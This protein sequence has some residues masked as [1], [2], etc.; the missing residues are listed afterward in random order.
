MSKPGLYANIHAKRA[1][2]EKMRDKGDKGA[3]SEQDFIDSAKTA[4]KNMKKGGF[5]DLTGDGKVTR[6]DILK[7][8]GVDLGHGGNVCSNRKKMMYGGG[9]KLYTT[10][11]KRYGGGVP[12]PR[13]PDPID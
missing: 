3:P 9:T 11:N 13:M 8:R 1:R 7:G 6:K 5:P 2:G 4:K 12:N 10:E